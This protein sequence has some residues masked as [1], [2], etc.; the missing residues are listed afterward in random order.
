MRTETIT[1]EIFSFDELS[2]EAKEKARDWCR[3][4]GLDDVWHS[5]RVDSYYKAEDR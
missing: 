2:D 5:E 3:D 1:K 4:G